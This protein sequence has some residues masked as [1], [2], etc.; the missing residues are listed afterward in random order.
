MKPLPASA[1]MATQTGGNESM[2]KDPLQMGTNKKE[3]ARA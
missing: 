3:F 1:P 2:L